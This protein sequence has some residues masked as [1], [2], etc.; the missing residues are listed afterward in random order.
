MGEKNKTKQNNPESCAVRPK[1]KK[2]KIFL[3]GL[4]CKLVTYHSNII[5]KM[6]LV[7]KQNIQK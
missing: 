3:T 2:K 7:A 6:L 5:N 1:K 4:S